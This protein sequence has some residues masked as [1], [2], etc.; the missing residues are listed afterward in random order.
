MAQARG[1]VVGSASQVGVSM[2]GMGVVVAAALGGMVTVG[3][4]LV[5]VV[6][7]VRVIAARFADHSQVNWTVVKFLRHCLCVLLQSLQEFHPF[8]PPRLYC[9]CLF[10]AALSLVS[11]VLLSQPLKIDECFCDLVLKP[12]QNGCP[13]YF[14]TVH[15]DGHRRVTSFRCQA[16]FTQDA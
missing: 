14:I 9:H 3:F 1:T 12:A 16:Q 10:P 4:Q 13:S 15:K 5:V 7:V 11:P 6:V 8:L 2:G